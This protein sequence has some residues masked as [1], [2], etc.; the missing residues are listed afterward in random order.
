MI[1]VRLGS[2]H[3]SDTVALLRPVRSDLEGITGASRRV[4]AAAGEKVRA[5]LEGMGDLPV[6][7][8][9][10][11]PGGDLRVGFII[12]VVLLGPDEAPSAM[13]IQRALVNG[14]RRARE[15]EIASLSLPPLGLGVGTLEPEDSAY[16]MVELLQDHLREGEPPGELVIVVESPYEEELF[17]RLLAAAGPI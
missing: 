6:S 10:L 5:R 16:M 3:E 9:V 2:L 14:L 13:G 8:A 1:S 12:H 17:R 7:S 4:E 15:W 11:T